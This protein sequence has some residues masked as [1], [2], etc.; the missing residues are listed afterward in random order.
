MTSDYQFKPVST[1]CDQNK[2]LL[3]KLKV[4]E[5]HFQSILRD[6]IVQRFSI[7]FLV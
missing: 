2:S 3:D 4:T 6:A 5:N 1:C 7:C